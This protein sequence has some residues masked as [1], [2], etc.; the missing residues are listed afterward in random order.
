MP[1]TKPNLITSSAS[2]YGVKRARDGASNRGM[3]RN[4]A[5]GLDNFSRLLQNE[6]AA[7]RNF[8]PQGRGVGAA[9]NRELMKAAGL[10]NAQPFMPAQLPGIP[11]AQGLMPANNLAD[12]S[13]AQKSMQISAQPLA[14]AAQGFR[15]LES[16]RLR[17]GDGAVLALKSAA[18]K[19]KAVAGIVEELL[20]G[21]MGKLSSLFESGRE[22]VAA[23]GYDKL[24]GTSYGT[25]QIASNTG[26]FDEFLKYLDKHAPGYARELRRSGDAN[27][28][29]KSGP[30]PDAWRAIAAR[31]PEGF[32]ALQHGFIER[33]LYAPAAKSLGEQG[34]DEARLG[35][36]L[37]EVLFST[38]VQHG[39]NGAARIVGRAMRG[40]KLQDL[41]AEEG[42]PGVNRSRA[43]EMAIRRIYDV[44]RKQF[45]SS[46]PHVREAVSNRLNSEMRMALNMLKTGDIG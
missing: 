40:V 25:Y 12:M 30:A 11:G 5:L 9:A 42:T 18:H 21:S 33:R 38:A 20:A 46:A 45:G 24:G 8:E 35:P 37:R 43:E 36:V 32:N 17:G 14:M 23:I 39:P 28:G 31:D 27:T 6:P 44:R 7:A 22:G 16:V 19:V 15:S 3:A 34:I 13:A 4:A 26:T 41:M 2:M 10:D 29:S 1:V